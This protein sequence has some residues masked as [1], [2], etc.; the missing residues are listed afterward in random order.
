MRV[1]THTLTHTRTQLPRA[2]VGRDLCGVRQARA[3]RAGAVRRQAG[4]RA[5]RA[6]AR[7]RARTHTH[8]THFLNFYK[9]NLKKFSTRACAHVRAWGPRAGP[10]HGV[11]RH[12]YTMSTEAGKR[13]RQLAAISMRCRQYMYPSHAVPPICFAV[14][15]RNGGHMRP[16]RHDRDI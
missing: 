1:H 15:T 8:N 6:R 4:A 12:H 13:C 5:G 2:Q 9:S 14:C 7:V 11:C 10:K 3:G 16:Y